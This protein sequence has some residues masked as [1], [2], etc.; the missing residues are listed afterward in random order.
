MQE[1]LRILPFERLKRSGDAIYTA[2]IPGWQP[3]KDESVII[4]TED[5]TWI[6]GKVLDTEDTE[7]TLILWRRV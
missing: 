1:S 5:D 2:K 7:A 4:E 6:K 3:Y